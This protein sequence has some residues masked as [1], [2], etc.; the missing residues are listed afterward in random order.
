MDIQPRGGILHHPAVSAA[1]RLGHSSRRPNVVP[2]ESIP[3][4]PNQ[5]EIFKIVVI[6]TIRIIFIPISPALRGTEDGIPGGQKCSHQA[7]EIPATCAWVVVLRVK[8]IGAE[9]I[10]VGCFPTYMWIYTPTP[11]TV[12]PI[13]ITAANLDGFA[14]GNRDWGKHRLVVDNIHIG[15]VLTYPAATAD[16]VITRKI[17]RRA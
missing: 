12:T 5:Y 11:T 2:C 7:G 3:V 15:A 13:T 1:L 17:P 10:M 4:C 9:I 16:K 14:G 8:I 6:S